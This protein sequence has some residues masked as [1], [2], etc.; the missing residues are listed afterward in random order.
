[1]IGVKR[2]DREKSGNISGADAYRVW[3][4]DIQTKNARVPMKR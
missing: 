3:L 2:K 4:R 1:M